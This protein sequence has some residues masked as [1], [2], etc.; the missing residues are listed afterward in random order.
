MTPF[1]AVLIILILNAILAVFILIW[2]IVNKK[3]DIT[4][5]HFFSILLCPIVGALFFICSYFVHKIIT[6][7]GE[8][9]YGDISFDTA[10]HIK[11]QKIDFKEEV[12]IVPLE[13]AFVVSEKKDRRSALLT[14]LKKENKNISTILRGLNNEDSETRHYAASYVLSASTDYLNMVS[15]LK[16]EYLA[17]EDQYEPARNYLDGLKAFMQSDILDSIDKAK[18]IKIHTEV[19][20]SV[21]K[22]FREKITLEDYIHEIEI[23]LESSDY[24]EAKMWCEYAI[25]SFPEDDTPYLILMKIYYQLGE[26]EKFVE[27]LEDIMDSSIN[28][29][30]ETLNIIRFFNSRTNPL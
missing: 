8:L 5:V 22:N 25:R 7:K 18:Y 30:N 2:D 12:D 10:R 16:E 21:H 11:K 9:E 19:L 20:E 23:L 27:L 26:N 24:D 3:G 1:I 13:E 28:I 6:R 29:S 14:V 4:Y 17:A 15:K